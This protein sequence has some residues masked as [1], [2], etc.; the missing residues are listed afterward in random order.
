MQPARYYGWLVSTLPARQLALVAARRLKHAATERARELSRPFERPL[1]L[2]REMQVPSPDALAARMREGHAGRASIDPR[3]RQLARSLVQ[4]HF[5]EHANEVCERADRVLN[6]ELFLFGAWRTHA[7]GELEPGIAALDWTRDPISGEHTPDL[8][9]SQIDRDAPGRDTRAVW[10]AG[11]LAHLVW[12]AQ[13]HLLASM[14]GA[15]HVRGA[16]QPGLYARALTLHVRDFLATQPVGLGIHWTCAMEAALRAMNLALALSLVRDEPSFDAPFWTEAA[17]FLVDHL[18]FVDEHLE[19]AQAVPG[20]HL[21]CDLAGQAVV[22]LLF[23]ELP[24][25]VEKRSDAL[26]SYAKELLTQSTRDGLS[27]ESSLPYHRFVTELSLLV[28]AVA[29]RQGLTLG[30][31]ALSRLWL[32]CDVVQAATLTDGKLVALGDDDSSRALPFTLRDPRDG[33]HIAPLKAALGGGGGAAPEPEVLWVAGV[34]GLRRLD[35]T[36]ES[37]VASSFA[38]SG[39][40]VLRDGTRSASLW[41]GANGQMGLGGHA[42]NDKLSC[43]VVLGGRRLTVDPGCPVYFAN[44]AERDLFRSTGVHPTVRVDGLEQSELPQGRPFVLP[45]IARASLIEQSLRTA[46]GE[47]RAYARLRPAVTHRREV[48]LPAGLEAVVVTDRLLGEGEHVCEVQWPV[49][50]REVL[51]RAATA[52]ERELL[53][54]LEHVDGEGRFDLTRVFTLP[55]R[56]EALLAI[57]SEHPWESLIDAGTWSPG[58]GRREPGR[59]IRIVFHA[60]LPLSVTC[61]FVL[62]VIG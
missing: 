32:M 27:F 48:S 62:P 42:H 9:S 37:P 59:I 30:P 49:P 5:P 56:P 15:E 53:R 25:A 18:R 7:R 39:L 45:D 58:Y 31:A 35:R 36:V 29:R 1:D 28:E 33:T 38:A 10:E 19:D 43:E 13:A 8:P 22:T 2:V 4:E 23:P 16:Q 61:A 57:A 3:E 60:P 34:S 26:D 20:N 41:A 55:G 17:T 44:L 12:F 24:G 40:A 6:G 54:K 11:R 14:P 47:H 52:P 46:I 51:M 50:T 21:L